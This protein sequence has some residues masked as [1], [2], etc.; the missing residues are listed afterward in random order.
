[1]SPFNNRGA[2]PDLCLPQLLFCGV[3][4][5]NFISTPFQTWG[6][7]LQF[8]T[9]IRFLHDFSWTTLGSI[10]I[11]TLQPHLSFI[12]LKSFIYP[13]NEPDPF[14]IGINSLCQYV[15]LFGD[16]FCLSSEEPRWMTTVISSSWECLH[17]L[18]AVNIHGF[19]GPLS[20]S[21]QK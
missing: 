19:I 16:P 8:P 11:E 12:R 9:P 1:M 14:T 15:Y 21:G 2:L 18:R 7:P 4:Y 20:I 5:P 10:V 6:G 13:E 17:I 3:F